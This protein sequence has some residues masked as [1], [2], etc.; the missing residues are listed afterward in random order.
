MHVR[1]Y[2][3]A[4]PLLAE[5]E[6]EARRLGHSYI[7]PEHLLLAVAAHGTPSCRAFLGGHEMSAERLRESV[8]ELIGPERVTAREQS[9]LALTHR[10]VVALAH[11]LS[12][13]HHARH[14]PEPYSPADLLVALLADDVAVEGTLGA[15]FADAGLT[16]A[17]AR[18]ELASVRAREPAG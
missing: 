17:A 8:T 4:L 14:W 6:D 16:V 10:S 5:A 15:L 13:G 9:S 11:A 7:G 18:A 1:S 2:T 12:T 3:L